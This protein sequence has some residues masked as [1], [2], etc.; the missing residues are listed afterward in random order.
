MRPALLL[1]SL[2]PQWDLFMATQVTK[3]GGVTPLM[4]AQGNHERDV[5]GTGPARPCIAHTHIHM[6]ASVRCLH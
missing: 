5:P 4:T 3:L 2:L 6:L 1:S